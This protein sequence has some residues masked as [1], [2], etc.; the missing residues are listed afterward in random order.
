MQY[1]NR[2][3]F[4]AALCFGLSALFALSHTSSVVAFLFGWVGALIALEPLLSRYQTLQWIRA[5]TF[6]SIA[7]LGTLLL[8][9]IPF[10]VL[11]RGAGRPILLI[12][13]Y[14]NHGSVWAPLKRQLE[15]LHL[16]PIFTVNLGHPFRS[17]REY[18]EKVKQ[19]AAEIALETGR[20]DLILIGHSMGGLV[21]SWYA[22]QL[23]AP[24]TV[25]DVITIAS[26]LAG[27]HI[28]RIGFG[29]N[30]REMEPDSPF[31][32]E[33]QAAIGQNTEI[34]FYHIATKTDQLVVPYVSAVI[35]KN[36]HFIFNDIG[37][38]SLIFS[39]KVAHKI[40]EWVRDS[41]G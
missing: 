41:S 10:R 17:I 19:R 25:T 6:E 28:A 37:H 23:A 12:H 3:V 7:F 40:H 39:K 31:I 30:A 35:A 2:K 29:Q 21:A 24:Q 27:T 33:L 5:M 34:R 18:A 32:Q 38:A 8:R 15:A 22:T 26:P 16:G 14:V 4:S 13:G 11:T 9:L 36:D 20:S 1:F